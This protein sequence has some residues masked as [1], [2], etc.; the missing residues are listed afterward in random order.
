[1]TTTNICG[2]YVQMAY[3]HSSLKVCSKVNSKKGQKGKDKYNEDEVMQSIKLPEIKSYEKS[4]DGT[5]TWVSNE[6][7]KMK[8]GRISADLFSNLNV[9]SHGSLGKAAQIT[10]KSN[11]K[12]VVA[13]YDPSMVKSVA[14]A[15]RGCG[16]N[17]NPTIEGTNVLANIP[18]PSKESRDALVKSAQKVA[19]KVGYFGLL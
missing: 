9:E 3:F 19:E 15:I 17:L 13:V 14:D 7:A 10:M 11:S 18:K 16:L 6:F 1:M 8:V 12:L 2:Y 4:M 5:L